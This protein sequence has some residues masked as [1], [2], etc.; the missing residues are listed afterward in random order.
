MRVR[1]PLTYTK[2]LLTRSKRDTQCCVHSRWTRVPGDFDSNGHTCVIL[3]QIANYSKLWQIIKKPVSI[4]Y[5]FIKFMLVF[6]KQKWYFLFVQCCCLIF[7]KQNL[8]KVFSLPV[9][10]FWANWTPEN[11]YT[12]DIHL[13]S[14]GVSFNSSNSYR[15]FLIYWNFS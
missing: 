6:P 3:K 13:S 15:T 8:L 5:Q 12:T 4:D 1:T 9:G 14:D 7:A 10:Q 2:D 11:H